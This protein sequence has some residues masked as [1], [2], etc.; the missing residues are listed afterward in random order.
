MN[1]KLKVVVLKK[2]IEYILKKMQWITILFDWVYP[3]R[4]VF[5]DGLLRRKEKF[6]CSSCRKK[7]LQIVTEPR[8]K[9]CGKQ[10]L[11]AEQE[12]CY[13]CSHFSHAFDYGRGLFL[14][15]EPLK[16][17]VMRFKFSGRKEYGQYFGRIM[18]IQSADFLNHIKPEVIIPVPIHKKKF[19]TRG[20]NQAEVL[21]RELS[22]GLSIPVRTDLVLRKKFTKAQKELGKKERKKNLEKAFQVKK[23]IAFYECVLLVDDIYTTGSTIHAIAKKLKESGVKKVYFI[24]LCIGKG[25]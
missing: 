10:I 20:Y 24:S 14:Y 9:K 13:D 21:A 3:R 16:S 23:E 22:R 1:N 6:L 7:Q 17:A 12:Y 4:C 25:L 19:Y 8:C 18:Q 15:Q 11:T 2:K 5:C